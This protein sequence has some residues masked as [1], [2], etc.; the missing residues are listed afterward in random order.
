[1]SSWNVRV[2]EQENVIEATFLGQCGKQHYNG[3][4]N[5]IMHVVV[6]HRQAKK[7]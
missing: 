2:L 1:V 4:N 3:A 5:N 7:I 6:D